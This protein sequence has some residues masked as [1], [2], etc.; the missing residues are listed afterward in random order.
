M[1]KRQTKK[2]NKS[3]QVSYIFF[4]FECTQDDLLQCKEGYNVGMKGRCRNCGKSWCDTYQHR[5]NLCVVHKVCELCLHKP[6]TSESCCESCGKNKRVFQGLETTNKFCTWLFSEE[7]VG[8]TVIC[9][10]FKGYDSYPILQ[11]LHENAILP[12]VISTGSKYMSIN[13]P[14][15]KIR[16]IDSLNF[17]PMPLAEMPSAF[18]ETELAKGYFPHLFNRNFQT[19]ITTHPIT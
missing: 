2:T 3:S 16:M 6:V 18:G 12:Q 5:P 19:R 14:V 9:H 11:Y 7:N 4:D 1:N 8:A 10:N 17:I 15:C 13:V